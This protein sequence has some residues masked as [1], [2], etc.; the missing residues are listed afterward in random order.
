MWQGAHS[1]IMLLILTPCVPAVILMQTQTALAFPSHMAGR[2]LT[3]FNLVMFAAGFALQWGI[4]LLVDT[5]KL[6]GASGP[7]S[8]TL[9]F[10][11]LAAAQIVTLA[12][13]ISRLKKR[14]SS[15]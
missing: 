2:V 15:I 8:M 9:A 14:R 11:S 5:F 4:G 13:F 10:A 7:M 12:W 1:W 3:T 6:S